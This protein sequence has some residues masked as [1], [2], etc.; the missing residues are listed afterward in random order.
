[1]TKLTLHRALARGVDQLPNSD[2]PELDAQVLLAHLL[3]L[4]RPKL[5]AH[6]T[7]PLEP[8]QRE[9]FERIIGQRAQGMPVAYL[10]GVKEFYGRPFLVTPDVLIPRPESELLVERALAWLRRGDYLLDIGTGSGCLGLS[11]AAERPGVVVRLTDISENALLVAR[12]NAAE[13]G[14]RGVSFQLADLLPEDLPPADRTVIIANL[15]Y[16]PEADYQA[17]PDLR[18]E[19]EQA[20]RSGPD[21]LD[22]IRRLLSML[23]ER[24]YRPRAVLLEVDPAQVAEIKHQAAGKV[25]VYQD[26]AGHDRVIELRP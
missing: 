7:D 10:T 16:V 26:L 23:Q 14:V 3:G 15:P 9:A 8:G 5:L 25:T 2:T 13:L 22:A 12:H 20:L 24:D 18:Y 1:M 21:G 4:T 19:P 11:V 6:L 17:N